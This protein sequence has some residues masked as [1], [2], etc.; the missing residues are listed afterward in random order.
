MVVDRARPPIGAT[1]RVH[2]FL[3]DHHPPITPLD[4]GVLDR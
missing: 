1:Y 4:S 3:I 2:W